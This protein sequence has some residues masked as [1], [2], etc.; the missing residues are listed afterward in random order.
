MQEQRIAAPPRIGTDQDEYYLE[1]SAQEH[2]FLSH[3]PALVV[4]V[5]EA[6]RDE[7][8]DQQQHCNGSME[9]R[10]AVDNL[11]L[12]HIVHLV[13]RQPDGEER[14]VGNYLL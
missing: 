6:S 7:H 9:Q 4:L 12:S 5:V 10:Q 11:L 14:G 2:V 3:H 8:A 1:G 13:N